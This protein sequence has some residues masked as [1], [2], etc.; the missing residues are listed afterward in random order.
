MSK[1]TRRDFIKTGAGALSAGVMLPVLD[2]MQPGATIV[3]QLADNSVGDGR[4]LV[5]LELAGGIDGLNMIVPLQQYD[6]YASLRPN[7]GIP[8]ERVLPLFGTTTMGLAPELAELKPIV[9]AGKLAVVQAVG[10]PQPNLSHDGSRKIWYTGNPDPAAYATGGTGWI[11]RQAALF[12]SRGNSLDTVSVGRGVNNTLYAAGATA[13][14]I[15][16]ENTSNY[17]FQSNTAYPG[18][19]N[20]QLAAVQVMDAETAPYPFIDLIEQAELN[21]LNGADKVR[22]ALDSYTRLTGAHAGH[23]HVSYTLTGRTGSFARGLQLI[24]QLATNDPPTG[25]RVYYISLG[26]FDTHAFQSDYRVN[27][28]QGDQIA[29]LTGLGKALRN[30]Y[31]DLL[32]HNL[33]EQTVIMVWS[34]FGRRVAD[35]ASNGTDHGEGNNVL[36]LGGRI[37]GG[38][39]GA[40]PSLTDLNRGNLKFKVD[41]RQVYATLIRD[42]LGGDAAPVLNGNFTP[43]GFIA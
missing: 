41:F 20:N 9:D 29:L 42:W 18:D 30:F 33:A 10:Y 31:D 15:D 32:Y 5:I 37:K 43:L 8:K 34:E 36:L 21:A 35:N 17:Q 14:C 28:A 19:H 26:G 1:P 22:Q 24:A 39:Y 6:T 40:D 27:P 23:S 3:K 4:I 38:V 11:G 2:L 13:A 12:G 7:V 25:T 16:S